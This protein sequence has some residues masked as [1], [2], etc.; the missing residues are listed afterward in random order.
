MNKA[1]MLAVVAAHSISA[2]LRCK[3]PRT[4]FFRLGT[5]HK[6]KNLAQNAICLPRP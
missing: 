2:G 6:T 5:F 4:L 3:K 1:F